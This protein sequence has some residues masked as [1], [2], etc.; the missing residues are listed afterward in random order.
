MKLTLNFLKKGAA[1]GAALALLAGCDDGQN[2][3][4]DPLWSNVENPAEYGW[5]AGK[6]AELRDYL[7]TVN[8]DSFMLITKDK[9][10]PQMPKI[11]VDGYWNDH[12]ACRTHVIQSISKSVS[13]MAYGIAE[14]AGVLNTKD[15]VAQYLEAGNGYSKHRY[16]DDWMSGGLLSSSSRDVT[17]EHIMKNIS[18]RDWDLLVDFLIVIDGGNWN[19]SVLSMSQEEA[20]GTVWHY[21]NKAIQILEEVFDRAYGREGAMMDVLVND[22]YGSLGITEYEIP[23]DGAGNVKVPA[24]MSLSTRDASRLAFMWMNMG[25]WMGKEVVSR[26]YMEKATR[27]GSDLNSGYGMLMWTNNPGNVWIGAGEPVET[28]TS[29]FGNAKFIAPNGPDNMFGG[30]GFGSQII[31]VSP[32]E[33]YAFVRFG[34][35]MSLGKL[36]RELFLEVHDRIE[37]ARR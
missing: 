33:D 19:D 18:G 13:S 14:D 26:E 32:D 3:S 11:L 27:A 34:D 5:D 22:L 1:F 9:D 17:I 36:G 23:T 15:K 24:G 37:A 10:N 6:L 2:C 30:Y 20:P 12:T 28:E 8:T 16:Y 21:N 4:D 25:S 7:G 35:D 29:L 31:V